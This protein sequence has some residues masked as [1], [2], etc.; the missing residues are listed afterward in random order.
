MR[1]I[2]QTARCIYK[3]FERN[4]AYPADPEDGYG[5]E[6]Y[7]ARECVDISRRITK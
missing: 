4:D 5:C 6:N 1:I 3:W 7:L 2:N